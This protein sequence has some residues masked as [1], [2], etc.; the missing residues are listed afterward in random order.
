MLNKNMTAKDLLHKLLD[1]N[2][3]WTRADLIND[4]P[5]VIR[6]QQIE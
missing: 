6:K 1:Y 4:K 2:Y 5:S 3:L